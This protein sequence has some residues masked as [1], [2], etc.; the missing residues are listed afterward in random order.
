MKRKKGYFYSL[1][2]RF[3]YNLKLNFYDMTRDIVYNYIDGNG[4]KFIIKR[5]S[6]EYIPVKPI[7]SSSGIYDGGEHAIK[8]ISQVIYDKIELVILN[9]LKNKESHTKD[10]VK[11]SGMIVINNK[12]EKE[13]SILKPYSDNLTKIE[14]MLNDTVKNS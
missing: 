12:S 7:F 9:G 3:I 4:N 13:I 1:I 6:I 14:K 10:R 8:E 11:G 5:N 2:K